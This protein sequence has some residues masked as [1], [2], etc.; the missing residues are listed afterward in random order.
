MVATVMYGR[1]AT[2][3][4]DIGV[5]KCDRAAGYVGIATGYVGMMISG[6]LNRLLAPGPCPAQPDAA[7]GAPVLAMM[8]RNQCRSVRDRAKEAGSDRD[9]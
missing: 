4:R 7:F 9:R 8:Q 1:A 3:G 5:Q 6:V 2:G